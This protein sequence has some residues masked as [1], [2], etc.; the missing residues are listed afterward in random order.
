MKAVKTIPKDM[1]SAYHDVM[2][3]IEQSD[4]GDT[5]LALKVLSWVYR[6]HRTLSI[7]ELCEC[8]VVE[9]G[10]ED[11]KYELM[12]DSS[13]VI[14]CCKSLVVYDES[15]NMVRF[16]HY[17]V[18]E[19]ISCSIEQKLPPTINLAKTCVTYLAFAEFDKPRGRYFDQVFKNRVA[20]YKFSGYV[21][22]YWASHVRGE[23]EEEDEVQRLVFQAFESITKTDARLEFEADLSDV[24][25]YRKRSGNTL[26]HILAD[27]GLATLLKVLVDG[28]ARSKN[29]YIPHSVS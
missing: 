17:T 11:L 29:M 16:S 21:A 15:T 2:E 25:G 20:R 22:K 19:F 26:L 18:Q 24:F 9:V 27:K 1:F 23:A 10:D 14:D 6:A 28:T 5:K 8:L 7:R 12:P 3:R 13:D 4:D